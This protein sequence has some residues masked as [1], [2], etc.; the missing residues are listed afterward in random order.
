[1]A[2][3][4]RL[5]NL[6]R[7]ARVRDEIDE[8]LR[9][10]IDARIA[11]NI[12]AGMSPKEARADALRR[13][14]GAT[15]ALE[16]SHDADI[17]VWLGTILQDIRFGARSLR[18]NPGVTA[19]AMLSLSLATGAGTAIFSVVNAVLL[20]T[21]PYKAPDRIVML[22]VTNSL[23]GSR[24]MNASPPNFRDWRQR[25]HIFSDLASYREADAAFSVNGVPDWIEYAWVYGDFFPLLGR[26]PLLGR[27]FSGEDAHEVVLSHRL[28]RSRFGSS[29]D[30][31]GRTVNLSG[32]D[33]QVVGVMPEDFAFPSKDTLLWAPPGIL[34]NWPSWRADRGGGFGP[35]L[36]RL[37]PGATLDQ[38]RAEMEV[39]AHQLAAEYPKENGDRGTRLAPLAAEIH[40][41]TVPFMLAVLSGAVLLVLLIACANAA[42]LL[43]ARGAVRRRE[44]AL[45]TALGAARGRILRQL[46]T[47]SVLLSGLA[48]ALGLPFAAWS[49]RALVALAPQGI[50][51]LDEARIDA[52]VMIFSLCLSVGTG[53]LFG[54]A[55]AIRIS[56]AASSRRHT[57]GLESRGM[58]RVFVVA[59]VALAVVLLTGAGLLI[60]SF[61]AMQGV[62]PGFRTFR[63][64]AATLRFRNTLKRAQRAALYRET[65]AR[66][67]QAP[68]VRAAGGVSTM[69]FAMDGDAKFGL[70]AVEGHPPESRREWTPMSWE[71]ISGDYFQALN[72]PLLRGRFFN[73]GD[74]RLT[75]PVVIIN[76][77]MARRYWPNEDPLGKGIKGFDPRGRNDDWVRVIGVVKDMHSGGLEH[78]PVAQIYEAQAQSLEE[79]E[80]VVVRT[81]GGAALLRDTIRSIDKTAVW[82]DVTAL[83]ER[84]REQSGPRRFQT[85]LL[86]LFAA[87][88]LVLTAAGIFAMMHYS[89]AQR[90]LEIGIRMALGAR[91]ASVVRMVLR[92][93]LLLVGVGI[94]LGLAGSLA[95]TRAIRSLLFEVGPGD[96]VTLAA[97]SVVLA[98]IALLASYVPARR[99]TRIDPMLALRCD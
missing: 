5:A 64:L 45:R 37:R 59:E 29:A 92:E 47:E 40:G 94:T 35:G 34:P 65:M 84:L 22:W 30:V 69:F 87:I 62:D 41:K 11:D 90:T 27:V 10:H 88:A 26:S 93:G 60:R 44:I 14:G 19:V 91:H 67:G 2:W 24:E 8:E 58:R 52:P 33:V 48:G 51:R 97:V 3:W 95:L 38:A 86:S 20:R 78:A 57:S 72:I 81:D 68:G 54:L 73:D 61:Q 89:V 53:L 74:S 50:A 42:N 32:I 25:T 55:P 36:A 99:A 56:Q 66:I 46:V 71:T 96:P 76:Q 13:F 77:S 63:V 49:I 83:D 79:T 98:A 85:L 12:A 16:K 21:L 39:I 17:L 4:N 15:V 82:S 75:T 31:V 80:D 70:R 43:L 9:Y 18:S 7:T 28:W 6:F 1:M 23:N